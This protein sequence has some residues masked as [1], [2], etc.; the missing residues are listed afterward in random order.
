MLD[1]LDRSREEGALP[2]ED[3]AVE[4]AA[5]REEEEAEREAREEREA[6]MAEAESAVG[7]LSHEDINALIKADWTPF[8]GLVRLRRDEDINRFFEG[9]EPPQGDRVAEA[10]DT[11]RAVAGSAPRGAGARLDR[12]APLLES[13]TARDLAE[14]EAARGQK[15]L[16]EQPTPP[17]LPAPPAQER[18]S[19][20]QRRK[21]IDKM[22]REEIERELLTSALTGLHNRRAYED[23]ERLATQ[24]SIDADSLKWVND[25]LGHG[26]GDKLL[27]AIG[28][29][30][31]AETAEA[32]HLSGDEFVVQAQSEEAA[33]QVMAA[34]NVRLRD[35]VITTELPDGTR[36]TLNGLGVSYGIGSTLEEA[37]RALGQHKGQ[38]E[39]AGLRAARGEPPPQAVKT[40]PQGKPDRGGQ[41]P[42]E[43][44]VAETPAFGPMDGW[45]TNIFKARVYA[46]ALG[47]ELKEKKLAVLV[48]EIHEYNDYLKLKAE[49][50]V[51]RKVRAEAEKPAVKQP[52]SKQPT[53]QA[54]DVSQATPP[55]QQSDQVTSPLR[56]PEGPETLAV[57]AAV[58]AALD[59]AV[60]E[61]WIWPVRERN[62]NLGD[63]LQR[64]ADVDVRLLD[65][66][67]SRR[68]IP[69]N[70]YF[71][72]LHGIWA[73]VE[74]MEREA[75][76]S[77][78]QSIE[79]SLE[80]LE[81]KA[82]KLIGPLQIENEKAAFFYE[83]HMPAL[84]AAVRERL[85]T[86]GG[87][88]SAQG[89]QNRFAVGVD[90]SLRANQAIIN[91]A[92][93]G[94]FPNFLVEYRHQ[95]VI[96]AAD[97]FDA[98]SSGYGLNRFNEYLKDEAAVRSKA[99]AMFDALRSA[100]EAPAEAQAAASTSS[101]AEDR[102]PPETRG[103]KTPA[104]VTA[105]EPRAHQ[106]SYQGRT[107][108][109]TAPK[110]LGAKLVLIDAAKFDAAWAQ[111]KG[112]Y[113]GPGGSGAA[114]EGRYQNFKEWI[115]T[116][117]SIT[118]SWVGVDPHGRVSFGDGRHRL[119]VLRDAG[120]QALPVAMNK[121]SIK[122]A[123]KAGILASE[124]PSATAKA[125]WW[126]EVLGE[127]YAVGARLRELGE[128]DR[129]TRIGS[130]WEEDKPP[131][132][133]DEAAARSLLS[134]YQKELAG[135]ERKAKKTAQAP[136]T[137]ATEGTSPE[138]ALAHALRDRIL[139]N[140]TDRVTAP[141]LFQMA[142]KA[143]GGTAAEGKYVSKDAYDALELALNLARLA[144][145]KRAGLLLSS[146]T[147]KPLA[148][149][150]TAERA[151]EII[152]QFEADQDRLPTPSKRSGEQMDLQQFSTPHTHAH[153]MAWVANLQS[154]DIVLEPSAGTGSLV[155]QAL[156]YNPE[157]VH[158]NELSE[159]RAELV[160]ELGVPVSRENAAHINA[161]LP[162]VTPSVVLMNPPFSANVMMK[163]KKA[164]ET[165]A[166]H[167]EA[168]LK[169]LAPGGRL[170]ALL[171]R[172]MGFTES[173][174][175]LPRFREWWAKVQTEYNVRA[176][177]GISGREYRKFGTEFDTAL[178]VIDKTGPTT[179][180]IAHG[181]VEKV[182][183]LP[184][185]LEGIR[186]DRRTETAQASDTR[187]TRN[188]AESTAGE[189][190]GQKGARGAGGRGARTGNPV[191]LPVDRVVPAGV[192][193]PGTERRGG[194]AG[195]RGAGDTSNEAGAGHAVPRA[196]R[197][198]PERVALAERG[199]AAQ[200][201][202]DGARDPADL[203]AQ[204]Q[205]VG[206]PAG[207]SHE[208]LK[209]SEISAVENRSGPGP[210]LEADAVFE[211]YRPR[212]AIQGAKP[213]PAILA[214]SAAMASVKAPEST[215][216]P[217]LPKR[218]IE[219]GRLS[220]AQ[221]VN[222]VQAGQSHGELLP[223]G[224][225]RGYFIG[226]GTGVGKGAQIAGIILDNW[227]Q[228]RKRA[229]WVSENGKLFNDAGRDI[230][231]VGLDKSALHLQNK[232][233]SEIP[234]QEGVLFTTY[235][236]VSDEIGG[237]KDAT[238][239]VVTEPLKRLDQIVKWLGEDFD[240]VIAFD[241][242]HGMGN[243]MDENGARG[244]K[245]ASA[246]ALAGIELQ[247]RLPK[248][249][250]LYVSATGATKVENLAYT[251]RLGLWGEGTAFANKRDFIDQIKA[252]G[253]ATMEV[254]AKDMKAMGLYEARSLAF[255]G[256]VQRELLHS[257][258]PD[259][260]ETYNEI[261]RAWQLVLDNVNAA[262][263]ITGADESPRA[264]SNA[265]SQFWGSQQRFFNQVLTSLSVPT[266]IRDTEAQ[267]K[268]GRSVVMQLVNTNEAVQDRRLAQAAEQGIDLGD[269][270]INPRD[271]LM[272]Y[273][274]NGFPTQLY[275][276]Q[277]DD[278]GNEI[279]VPV[280]DSAGNPIEDPEAV[281]R[282]DA[283]LEKLASLAVPEGVL[284]QV[285]NHFG[286][287]AVA[288]ITG[289]SRRV[290][291][292][293]DGS[294][295]IE[296]L[297]PSKSNKDA[298]AFMQGKKRILIFSDAGGTGRSYH[299]DLKAK[300]QEKRVHYLVQPGWRAEKAVQGL[301]RTHRTNQ[302]HPPEYVLVTTN[303]KAQRR[304]MS[305]IARRL[306]QLGA[307]TKG[308]R[309]TASQGL[310]SAEMNLENQ[311]G[312]WALR[313]LMVD[314]LAGRVP[315]ITRQTLE[316]EMGLYLTDPETG[317][318]RE[319]RMPTVPRFLNRML[320][321]ESGTM[322]RV[323][324][325][326][327]ERLTAG[328][329]YA[330]EQGT[331]DVGM[332]TITA[333]S[334]E[335]VSDQV[336]AG[337]QGKAETRYVKLELTDPV[338]F[339][340]F[341]QLPW[342]YKPDLARNR[343]SGKLYA[344]VEAPT[345]TDPETGQ[346]VQRLRRLG[347][348]DQ[349]YLPKRELDGDAYEML[350]DL[351]REEL[352]AAWD[353][354][355]AKSPQQRTTEMHLVTGA[356][357]P[358]W[359]RLPADTPKVLRT[360][361]DE[362]ERLLGREIPPSD[363][364]A[365][366]KALGAQG[367]RPDLSPARMAKVVMDDNATLVLANG[368][369]IG[370]RVVS[371]EERI[372][373]MGPTGGDISIL[374]DQ[375]A[376]TEIIGFKN[377]VFVPTGT[378]P[379]I[380]ERITKSKPVVEVDYARGARGDTGVRYSY[381]GEKAAKVPRFPLAW[382]RDM[383]EKGTPMERI[384]KATGWFRGKDG[385]WRIEI[386]DREAELQ[387]SWASAKTVGQALKHKK[388][389]EHY[390]SL[391][392]I[393]I[394]W[395]TD[396]PKNVSGGYEM[397]MNA[398]HLNATLFPQRIKL[399]L[400]HE[401]QH[402]I[403]VIEGFARGGSPTD[404]EFISAAAAMGIDT[405]SPD[406]IINAYMRLM[407]EVE[408]RD[409]EAR[410][411]LTQEEL[412]A[413]PP[414]ESQGIP[415]S[416]FI[417]RR[418]G[419][420][421]ASEGPPG[422]LRGAALHTTNQKPGPAGLSVSGVRETLAGRF[423]AGVG[424]LIESD[425][426]RIVQREAELPE[427]LNDGKG[428]IR[429]VYDPKTDLTWMVADN[430]S[431]TD[432]PRVFLH[433]LGVHF[434]LERMVGSKKYE[435][436]IAEVKRME[437]ASDPAVL[438]ARAAIP[439]GTRQA[440]VDDELVAYL[441]E[442]HP[443]LPLVKRI[444]AAIR[445]FLFR[446]GLIKKIRP[447][448]VV[449]LARAAA[450]HA[451]RGVIVNP[452]GSAARHAA[453][454]PTLPS[455]ARQGRESIAYS[456]SPLWYS[457]MA[458]FID[459][460][461]PGKAPAAQWKGLLEGWAKQGKFKGDELEW[462]GV[463]DWLDLKQGPVTKGEVLDFVRDNG[464]RVEETTLGKLSPDEAT[465]LKELRERP[466]QFAHDYRRERLA[467]LEAKE[468]AET[469]HA[470]WQLPGG[471]NYRE[472]LLKLPPPSWW[473]EGRRDAPS[474]KAASQIFKSSHFDQPNILAHVRF[475][476]RTDAEGKK[477]LFLEEIQ[478]DWSAKVRQQGFRAE[479]QPALMNFR[480][481]AAG[482]GMAEREIERIRARQSGAAWEA[483]EAFNREQREAFSAPGAG[484]VP[485]APFVGKTEAWVGLALKRMIRHAAE[486][487]FDRVAWTT[488]EQQAERYDL[489]KQVDAIRA[490]KSQD[491]GP[492]T[493]VA[494]EGGTEVFA[495]T[496][497]TDAELPEL[498]G[499]DLA[500]KVVAQ[501]PGRRIY[502]G[503]DLKVGG[504][505]MRAFYDKIVPN[506]ASSLLKKLGGGR[507]GT[508]E[509][510]VNFP[511][512]L[513]ASRRRSSYD[514]SGRLLKSLEQPG[515]D[516]TP[517]LRASA[518]RGLPLFSQQADVANSIARGQA[519]MDR[520]IRSRGDEMEAMERGGLGKIA[521][522]WGNAGRL[523]ARKGRYVEGG[524]VAH[525]IAQRN[526][527]GKDGEATARA[528]PDV[529]A[530]GDVGP[531]YGPPGGKRV[532]IHHQGKT[533][534]L[535]LYHFGQER[536]WLLTGWE[537]GPGDAEGVNPNDTYAPTP[538][539]I[540]AEEGAG[541]ESTIEPAGGQIKGPQAP[542][543]SRATPPEG[544]PPDPGT[545]EGSAAAVD[546]IGQAMR[547]TRHGW[548]AIKS[549]VLEDWR[550]AWL[551]LFTRRQL[552]DIGQGMV[553][554]L[555]EYDRAVQRMDADRS[556]FDDEAHKVAEIAA[557]YVKTHRKEA[558]VLFDVMHS[559]TLAGTDPAYGFRPSINRQ[560]AYA[561]IRSL[562]RRMRTRP[563]DAY[564]LQAQID[565]IQIRL[566]NEK[567]R[568]AAHPA[569]AR[570]YA[571]LSDDAKAVYGEIRDLYKKRFDEREEALIQ[572]IR[573][574]EADE[575]WKA[576]L[577][578][579]IRARFETARLS[580]P[581]FPLT[582]FGDYWVAATN[583]DGEKEYHLRESAYQHK[584]L[585]QELTT[586]GYKEIA[587][588]FKMDT[589]FEQQGASAGFVANIIKLLDKGMKNT[590]GAA[591]IKDD[592]Y[593]MYLQSLPEL[594]ARK[595][596]IHRQKTPGFSKDAL[597]GFAKQMFH[598]NRQLARLRQQTAM[599]K[600]LAAARKEVRDAADP[601]RAAQLVNE[602]QKRD[603]WIKN[604][605]TATWAN[606][607]G[608]VGFLW[609]LTAPASAIVNI[610]QTPLVAYP[611]LATRHGWGKTAQALSRATA[612]YFK[613]GFTVEGALQGEELDAYRRFL[614]DGLIDKTQ[615]HDLAGMSETPS[616]IYSGRAAKV[617]RAASYM[618][619]RAE[620]MNREVTALA[621]Y[622]L[623]RADGLGVDAAYQEA[624]TLTWESHFDYSNSNKA[625]FI[626]GDVARVLF[627]FKQFSQHMTYLLAR[628]A[629]QSIKGMS[630]GIR[631]EA[632]KRL[633][634]LLGMHAL[635]AGALGMPLMGTLAMV[636][637]ALFDDDEDE[638]YDFETE[639]RNFLA[640]A[641]GP[642]WGQAIAKGPVESLTGLGIS[643]RVGLSDL[644]FREPDKSLEGRGLVEYWT[645]QLLGPLGGIAFKAGTGYEMFQEG[646]TTRALESMTP[647]P[648]RDGLRM[649]RYAGEGV[650]S[651]RGDPV[652]EDVSGWNLLW[653]GAGFSPAKLAQKYDAN[654]A[655]KNL[656]QRIQERRDRLINR[657]WLARRTGDQEGVREAM[658]AIRRFNGSSILR[659]NPRDRITPA[660]LLASTQQR[661]NYSRRAEG[662][663]IVDQ[664]LAR[665]P[666]RVKFAP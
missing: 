160:S 298:D 300:N 247:K 432:A 548:D 618:F 52:S 113:V 301:G 129:A 487:G 534:V 224:E 642:D 454:T 666:E 267:L 232:F 122:H 374:K 93:S 352:R 75:D 562:Q 237:E 219:E 545:P 17:N 83:K 389:F 193:T 294:T 467:T 613:G 617:M 350:A 584:A 211:Q 112:F 508:M 600:A 497:Q 526:L 190:V 318:I 338:R 236:T 71:R 187:R 356:L 99:R 229:V 288:E 58:D 395:H 70:E 241:E 49:S 616:G 572:R 383:A 588:G 465:E 468:A 384:R 138:V 33:L 623:G 640:E 253:V 461:A 231:W 321:L 415:E 502:T 557:G 306:D 535:S 658:E 571:T 538:S 98:T 188:S 357:L 578:A 116:H 60:K 221:L 12:D 143:Y 97:E 276:K 476:E 82:V 169:K 349:K 450:K 533:A 18:R 186:N 632:R 266:L 154:A 126:P 80:N 326:F 69:H 178:V 390:P 612:D 252:G 656:E 396:Y 90:N 244:V 296:P 401:L 336:I 269:I 606:V 15:S 156:L 443:E 176:V 91:A 146:P 242:A 320:A 57:E 123:E 583:P 315:G 598:G 89:E 428:G 191:R 303:L 429:G 386:S 473:H 325:A 139:N 498:I 532:N 27:A 218:I 657:W 563:G 10:A 50:D 615:S 258:T 398:I 403:Q 117:D 220:D 463:N 35:A 577:I 567:V 206:D 14:R 569:L 341:D 516:L 576:R 440:A 643:T 131:V 2:I 73:D 255:A 23:A 305:S 334:V 204:G 87:S 163:G 327:Y 38:R 214:E 621:A 408:A 210:A 181:K 148:E 67:V 8:D 610:T 542:L 436:I 517:E 363:L 30:I 272:Q 361:T 153:V 560:D 518:M 561:E 290:V 397:E 630:P 194:H 104:S 424:R 323:F 472:L 51:R 550:P 313:S 574:A 531:V 47:I 28:Q 369:R 245:K 173:G 124:A 118:T 503:L 310:F 537:E 466:G 128:H 602:M 197:E 599:E 575:R 11:R 262:L 481:W 177:Y 519:A 335:K 309:D 259:Q 183:D 581:Y 388:L 208:S 32:Y 400:L 580:A 626:Q 399:V 520:V 425:T 275:E 480:A 292:H 59:A 552:V 639:F 317:E 378:A 340:Q 539:G 434:G 509:L 441:V 529:I 203:R 1:E 212:I 145:E 355:I 483:W 205:D 506:V 207:L 189:Q 579:D 282:R 438:A 649:L 351:P 167:V 439:K 119:A 448:D 604:P 45:E 525:I 222:V 5:Q 367:E 527:E 319:N 166:E 168:G 152:D 551:G 295:E 404:K 150:E 431:A 343:K 64:L 410:S 514:K 523:D 304:F 46:K 95:A 311:Y 164:T 7:A 385:M 263:K 20:T 43:E 446:M 37:D 444:I 110:R 121:A 291:R 556:Q 597:R 430:L 149:G 504:E 478:S 636:M 373:V 264:K 494:V 299:A 359:D 170:V 209:R 505:G 366:L 250:I 137:T 462:S 202:A 274:T 570:R 55:S 423:G 614:A 637:N 486:N 79:R 9:A 157:A 233:K 474:A 133:M 132:G 195:L 592:I 36:I 603:E 215:Y 174:Q 546:R 198:R 377:R 353:A 482:Q 346:L 41:T 29:A 515:F 370:R 6:I 13:Y 464:V 644:W 261:A 387:Q 4:S 652:M 329:D 102:K 108:S 414:Y 280:Q 289:R 115:A 175:P 285:V 422:R 659:E 161:L 365:T 660:T 512:V 495:Q 48:A 308:Q 596:W 199:G 279:R 628:S 491:G 234:L 330:R 19:D 328:I 541:P 631:T 651:L 402:A 84:I 543:Y 565:Q 228:G 513:E 358:V 254:V 235:A 457:E 607:A 392:K 452:I 39:L 493:I 470:Q 420:Y 324:D 485:H 134:F 158:A 171:G 460:K 381:L 63:K 78:A 382:A 141:A 213:H 243:S 360:E 159:R 347:V 260:T 100:A 140:P 608:S 371:G 248:A 283:L 364:N 490:T 547:A 86:P 184:D 101:P 638:P 268:A 654:R 185:L 469:K 587:H 256:V 536:L 339:V 354:E 553:P 595:H 589:L 471:E 442:K 393:K 26:S 286:T 85:V 348:R 475:N 477:T 77:A 664:R 655:V 125:A 605:T 653:Q 3:N 417:I 271:V 634:G 418:E 406:A 103:G 24:V 522:L 426:L 127:I 246:K 239:K 633:T 453:R 445:A 314:M 34:V 484:G 342:T 337:G 66:P 249:R 427:D 147:Q 394:V 182:R 217:S 265:L 380:I 564:L 528:M 558:D 180:P 456:G 216:L 433:E 662:G 345:L 641:F 107:I 155:A 227:N 507:V 407:G 40:P 459:Q 322:D 96:E 627:M 663:I 270:D 61:H 646:H 510:P 42:A 287:K 151:A 94:D 54:G 458:R 316:Q 501:E 591:A 665:L 331:L 555:A 650:Q 661:R 594:S 411:Y 492:Y 16:L 65:E 281:G 201:G 593:Q 332:E 56:E 307:L 135:I 524:G 540:R 130:G 559:A 240:G 590:P 405:K 192:Q 376:F 573:D 647:G 53:E 500:E 362:G 106:I 379:E 142:T 489:S 416:A 412:R 223:N 277:L 625:R 81:R 293:K 566:D 611:L 144:R 435:E 496:V 109:V 368:W 582:R 499:K 333:Q 530:L 284:E 419:G 76:P 645:E 601:N 620:R 25:N 624:K 105:P 568:K 648:I 31:G 278:N 165:G 554:A 586:A 479:P 44:G 74:R 172:G 629:H 391:A 297:S 136:D 312:Q 609:Y 635:F 114:I 409:V 251:D 21:R 622:R 92:R 302:A 120:L 257:L 62:P 437:A 238:G 421:A 344:F 225:R 162:G 179:G 111:D 549:K 451:A 88:L 585:I 413:R 273:V 449:A 68:A 22:S 511:D 544:T 447:E 226:D 200:G 521:F 72:V 230:E 455:P 488:G 372:E 375:G 196:E 619:H